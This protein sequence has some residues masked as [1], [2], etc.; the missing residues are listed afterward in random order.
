[1]E[2]LKEEREG[3]R[4]EENMC[5]WVGCDLWNESWKGMKRAYLALGIKYISRVQ[6][7]LD[8]P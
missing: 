4:R 8:R 7:H 5:M 1:M 2:G 3:E 6:S